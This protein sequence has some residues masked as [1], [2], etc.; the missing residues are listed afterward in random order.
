MQNIQTTISTSKAQL[1]NKY[2]LSE[3]YVIG[4]T[5]GSGVRITRP[6]TVLKLSERQSDVN[7]FNKSMSFNC[8][9]GCGPLVHIFDACEKIKIMTSF[10]KT[11]FFTSLHFCCR[12]W[13]TFKFFIWVNI[14]LEYLFWQ[15]IN[16]NKNYHKEIWQRFLTH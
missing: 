4:E 7:Q 5:S 11:L 1:I 13:I 8:L 9:C 10:I 2:L 6:I 12:Y 16:T 3:L 15:V 14:I